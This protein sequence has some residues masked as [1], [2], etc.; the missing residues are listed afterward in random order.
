MSSD[1]IDRLAVV[2]ASQALS[3]E[4]NIDRLRARV[5]EVLSA[6]TGATSVRLLLWNEDAQGW[7]LPAPLGEDGDDGA[8]AVGVE[9]AGKSGM[10]CL[11]AFRYAERTR[12][13]LL[14]ADA[15]RDDRFARDPYLHGLASCSLLVVPIFSR[16]EP[17]AM[18]LLENRLSR[19]IFTAERLDAVV[20]ITGQLTVSLDNAL[21]YASLERKVAERTDALAVANERLEL[22][23]RHRSTDRA[24][25]PT[26]NGRRS[27]RRVAP[28][29][30]ATEAGWPSR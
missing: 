13:P 28:W 7:F 22:L 26:P 24:G 12:E 4:T 25:Q 20:L 9:E 15:T 21:L 19:G 27:R 18:L 5:V 1:S 16:G 14:V 29:R 30:C 3:S 10:I 2:R 6:M 11:S 8:A 23:S 17:R